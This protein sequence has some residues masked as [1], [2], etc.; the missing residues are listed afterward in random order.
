MCKLVMFA[1][2]RPKCRANAEKFV[3]AIAPIMSE[4]DTDG[5]G[6]AAIDPEGN[7]SGERW[8]IN[9]E[10]FK[11][12]AK[13]NEVDLA[14]MQEFNNTLI[15]GEQDG[16]YNKF[17]DVHKPMSAIMLHTRMATSGKEFDNTHP[18]VEGNTALI[19]N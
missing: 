5:L 8:H 14:I 6:Y 12:R 19:H 3:K 7:L 16:G 17:G 13:L 18:F 15:K 2:I 1:G 4:H 11:S 9:K 10:A